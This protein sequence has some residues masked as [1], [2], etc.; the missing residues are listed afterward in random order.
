M[1]DE[2]QFARLTDRQRQ[3]L[4]LVLGR[5]NSAEIAREMAASPTAIDKQIKKAMATLGVN[6]RF[7]AARLLAEH[8]SGQGS[9]LWTP[10]KPD[11]HPAPDLPLSLPL[12]TKG[13]PTNNFSWQ[14]VAV[15][16]VIIAIAFPAALAVA[17][18]FYNA[19]TQ[20]LGHFA[21]T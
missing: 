15:L 12:P 3:C 1:V 9:T 2:A 7:E 8:E 19:L 14:Q 18:M 20:V 4:R 13:R 6:S 10:Q 11:L 5:R 21:Q 16:G 17:V